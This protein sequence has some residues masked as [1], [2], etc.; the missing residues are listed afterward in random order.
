MDVTNLGL[1]PV[2]I[3]RARELTWKRPGRS[4]IDQALHRPIAAKWEG[5]MIDGFGPRSDQMWLSS[6]PAYEVA[7]LSK[8]SHCLSCGEV[9]V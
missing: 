2:L 4:V 9:R 7:R 6:R 8:A 5:P 3:E 1:V